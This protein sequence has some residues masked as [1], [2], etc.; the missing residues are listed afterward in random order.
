MVR[1]TYKALDVREYKIV[2]KVEYYKPY[3]SASSASVHVPQHQRVI[4]IAENIETK[5]RVRLEFLEAYEYNFLDKV[6]YHGYTG[7]WQFIVP[8]DIFVVE[9]TST[10]DNVL[11]LTA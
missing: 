4:V 5:K 11:I 9:E 7:D 6:R 3:G 10:F 8:G 2:G 1:N